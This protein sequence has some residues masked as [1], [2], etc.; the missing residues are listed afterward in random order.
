MKEKVNVTTRQL[1]LV[2]ASVAT[3]AM[4]VIASLAHAV[5]ARA[6]GTGEFCTKS[7]PAHEVCHGAFGYISEIVAED[8]QGAGV[9]VNVET[10]SGGAWHN[11]TGWGTGQTDAFLGPLSPWVYGSPT[12]Y[13]P[14]SKTEPF[15]GIAIYE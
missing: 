2:A 8:F 12:I 9:W 10:F 6:E 1:R 7:I 13:N 11:A 4:L 14:S 5:P 15:S 3:C